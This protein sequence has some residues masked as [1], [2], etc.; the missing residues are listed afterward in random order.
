MNIAIRNTESDLT[1]CTFAASR[2]YLTAILQ[3][4]CLIGV[5]GMMQSASA[6]TTITSGSAFTIDTSNVTVAGFLTT[7]NDTGT[8]TIHGG[9]TF[10]YRITESR[11]I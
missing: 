2:N 6:D 1:L 11:T 8:L 9:G 7:W 5:L 10:H 3:A 4:L